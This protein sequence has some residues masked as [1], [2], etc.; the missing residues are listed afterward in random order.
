[1]PKREP[2]RDLKGNSYWEGGRVYYEANQPRNRGAKIYSI[3][4]PMFII[5]LYQLWSLK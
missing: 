2:A 1:V 3:V 4:W 5:S